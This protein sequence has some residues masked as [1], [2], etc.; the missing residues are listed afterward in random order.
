M[1]RKTATANGDF[2]GNE[3]ADR[4]TKVSKISPKNNS[5][6]NEEER[7]NIHLEKDIVYLQNKDRKL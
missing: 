5:E 1:I 3:I 2:I 7:Y 4:I 6:T